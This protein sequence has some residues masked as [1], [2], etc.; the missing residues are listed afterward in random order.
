MVEGSFELRFPITP[1]LFEGVTF[2][3]WGQVWAGNEKIELSDLVWTPGLGVRYYSPIG[4]IRLDLAYRRPTGERLRVVTSQVEP[5]VATGEDRDP[6][7]TLLRGARTGPGFL[8]VGE[9]ALLGPTVPFDR[10]KSFL[11]RLQLHFSI[12]QAF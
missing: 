7:T 10:D 1:V 3:D 9:L 2:V 8:R 5:C 6:C 11:S 4:P 12:G